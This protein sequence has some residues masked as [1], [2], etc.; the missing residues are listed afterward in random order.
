MITN[1]YISIAVSDFLLEWKN[2]KMDNI[3]KDNIE[4]VCPKCNE[5]IIEKWSGI[6]CNKCEYFECY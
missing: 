4:E 6:K 1:P 5:P 3:N 2:K